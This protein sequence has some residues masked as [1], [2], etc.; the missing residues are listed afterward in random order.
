MSQVDYYLAHR[1]AVAE[2]GG[3]EGADNRAPISR[4]NLD[5]LPTQGERKMTFHEMR[6]MLA[7]PASA[8]DEGAEFA[9]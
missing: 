3:Q 9:R 1:Q 7:E 8:I 4:E 6:T 5:H 2:I